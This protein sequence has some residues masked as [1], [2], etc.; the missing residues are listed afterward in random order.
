MRRCATYAAL[1]LVSLALSSPELALPSD[2]PPVEIGTVDLEKLLDLS[3]TSVTLGEEPASEAAA[4]TFVLSGEDIRAQG[5]RTLQEVLRSIPGLFAYR[6][7]LFPSI[8]V[9]GVGL[10]IDYT[11]RFLVLVDGHPLNN[12]VGI[13][14]SYIGRDFPVPLRAVRRV[15]VIKGPV[16]SLYGPTAFLGLV[17][18]VTAGNEPE[19]GAWA[20]MDAAQGRLLPG[21]LGFQVARRVGEVQVLVSGE[22]FRSGG[23]T[24]VFPELVSATDRAA[25]PGGRV[26]GMSSADAIGGYGRLSWRELTLVG[27]CNRASSG[28]PTAPYSSQL[29]DDRNR[30]ATRTCYGQLTYERAVFGGASIL[31]RFAYDDFDYEDRFIYAPPPDSWG[32]Y[33]DLASARWS[34]AEA[35]LTWRPAQRTLLVAGAMGQHHDTLQH[36]FAEGLPTVLADPENGVGVGKILNRWLTLDT[37]LL[38]EQGVGEHVRLHAG[39]T[40][41][42]NELFGNRVTPKAAVIWTP[43]ENHVF[44]AVYSE[45]FRAPTASE[46]FF[47]DGTDFL[48]NPSLRPETVR[49]FELIAERRLGRAARL[50]LSVYQDDYRGLIQYVTVARPGLEGPPDPENPADFRQIG[51]NQGSLRLRGGELALNLHLG[52]NLRAWGGLAVQHVDQED[53][54]NFPG[55]TGNLAISTRALWRPL[56]LS[57]HGAFGASRAKVPTGRSEDAGELGPFLVMGAAALLDVPQVPGLSVELGIENLLDAHAPSPLAEDSTPVTELR[58][59]PRTFRVAVRWRQ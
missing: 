56:T 9:R 22:G 11:T 10:P 44:K 51:Q 4:S 42:L 13:G 38:A 59:P 1:A 58:E 12:S 21:T 18:V 6:D 16:G 15:E 53:F 48:A 39:L 41:Y 27:A 5:F 23:Y 31:A 33:R 32:T 35:R 7:D 24:Y 19:L 14:Q 54:P 55:V 30:L 29:L 28:M 43:D 45:G 52:A 34:T 37:Y 25:P 20:E 49:S 8:G 2:G 36:S 40:L 17:N 26:A 46:A 3:V 57:L 50:T 47:E